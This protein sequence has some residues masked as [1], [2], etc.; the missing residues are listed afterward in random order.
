M[1]LFKNLDST[2]SS[3]EHWIVY[4]ESVG[5]TH[6][7]FLNTTSA[8]DDDITYF[9]DTSPTSSVFSLGSGDKTNKSGEGQMAFCFA[10][11]KGFSKFGTYR[12]NGSTNGPFIYTGFK[13]AFVMTKRTDSASDW[14]IMDNKR[15]NEFN[16]VQNYLKAQASDAEQTDDSFNIDI[17]SNG[18]KARYNNGNYNASG[19]SYIYMAFAENPLVA[20]VSGGV[21]A[22]AR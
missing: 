22:T 11:K 8:E 13:P 2:S 1:I 5:N 10:E 3:A 20:N 18:W 4:H 6:G 9:N 7:L 21:P 17:L 12:G 16:V 15:P 14:A 19:G